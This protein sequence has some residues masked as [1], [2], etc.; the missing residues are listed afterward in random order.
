MDPTPT[1]AP[2]LVL[3]VLLLVLHF[4]D[5]EA[6][7]GGAPDFDREELE[8][9]VLL[10]T[11]ETSA[12]YLEQDVVYEDRLFMFKACQLTKRSAQLLKNV[13]K[14]TLLLQR[15]RNFSYSLY[16]LGNLGTDGQTM[17]RGR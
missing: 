5:P 13:E 3:L 10:A 9:A 17:L 7:Q 12:A 4:P 1:A 15:G 8:A 2:A 14:L 6:Q 16:R 11:T